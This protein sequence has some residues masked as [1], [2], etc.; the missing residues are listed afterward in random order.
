MQVRIA[1][2]HSIKWMNISSSV[3]FDRIVPLGCSNSELIWK[4][5]ILQAVGRTP[6]DKAVARPLPAQDNTNTEKNRRHATPRVGIEPIIQMFEWMKTFRAL[7]Q[8][9]L[10]YVVYR[11]PCSLLSLLVAVHT[12]AKI[13]RTTC[14]QNLITYDVHKIHLYPY[15]EFFSWRYSPNWGLGLPPWNSPFHFGF[16]DLR[17]TVG[18]LGRVISSY[19]NTEST[20]A[21][22]LNNHALSGIRTH[23]PVF[24]A[25]EDSSLSRVD[26]IMFIIVITRQL[27]AE[28]SPNTRIGSNCSSDLG[29]DNIRLWPHG[30]TDIG[31]KWGLRF[32]FFKPPET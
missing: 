16:L 32:Y 6:W 3:S 22:T 4:L 21:L 23:D 17:Q 11:I 26:W 30:W 14:H 19:T 12:N 10:H 24:R 31:S 27:L 7:H 2:E 1:D 29:A 20:H 5:W 28:V 13:C 18:L 9:A 8:S 15:V 25:S